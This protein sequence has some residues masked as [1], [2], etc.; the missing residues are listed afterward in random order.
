MDFTER[1]IDI[2]R[3]SQSIELLIKTLKKKKQLSQSVKARKEANTL[4]IKMNQLKIGTYL[5]IKNLNKYHRN[6]D[7]EL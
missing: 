4:L 5:Q 2:I 6:E 3:Q 1:E 7:R